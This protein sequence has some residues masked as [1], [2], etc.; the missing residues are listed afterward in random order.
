[1]SEQGDHD[2]VE[3]DRVRARTRAD[4]PLGIVLKIMARGY[5]L[6]RWDGDI[7]ETAHH[8]ELERIA[9]DGAT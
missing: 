5:I 7:L 6:V 3:G 8:S 2:F 9:V 1:M 4:F